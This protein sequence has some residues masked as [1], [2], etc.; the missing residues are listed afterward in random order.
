MAKLKRVVLRI[1]WTKRGRCW[2]LEGARRNA[3]FYE[4]KPFAIA[5]GVALCREIWNGGTGTPA[6]LVVHNKSGRGKGRIS[7]ERTYGRD[8]RRSRG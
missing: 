3:S 8:P 1:V 2:K 5:S 4:L 6:Q 7:F